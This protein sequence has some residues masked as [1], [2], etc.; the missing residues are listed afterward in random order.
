LLV[1][2]LG[3]GWGKQQTSGSGAK[4]MVVA[5]VYP[6]YEFARQVGGEH[7]A[8]TMLVPAGVEP[9][10]W[11]PTAKD[12]TTLRKAKL[13]LYHGAG[14]EPWVDKMITPQV[15]GGAKAVEISK[16]IEVM[17]AENGHGHAQAMDPHIWLDPVLAQKEVDN[18]LAALCAVDPANAEL[19][20]QNADRFKAELETLHNEYTAALKTVRQRTFITNHAAF[21]YL[22]RRYNLEQVAVM[23]LSPDAEPTPE[24]LAQIIDFCRKKQVKY[25][26]LEPLVNPRVA[27]TIAKETGVKTLILDPL[28]GMTD[29]DLRQGKNYLFIMRQNL[30][31]LKLALM[32]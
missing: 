20:R 16:N 29:E 8:V 18:I 24:T 5:S 26:F 3:C 27:N 31:N 11:E 30:A 32:E 22:A 6:V 1:L 25:I 2:T 9:H 13:F 21:G 14:L 12:L 23:G 28:D 7:V 19:Y 17:T 4:L 10:S 15:L